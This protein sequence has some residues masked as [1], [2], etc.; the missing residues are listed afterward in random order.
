M[1]CL[2][3][4]RAHLALLPPTSACHTTQIC[5]VLDIPFDEEALRAAEAGSN[6]SAQPMSEDSSGCMSDSGDDDDDDDGGGGGGSSGDEQEKE[7]L[8]E[9]GQRQV[10]V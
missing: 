5:G 7:L 6:D 1:R 3:N 8:I 4:L 9:C 10:R 2:A